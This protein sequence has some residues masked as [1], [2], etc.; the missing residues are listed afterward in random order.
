MAISCNDYSGFNLEQRN[1]VEVVVLLHRAQGC[2]KPRLV[3]SLQLRQVKL[4]LTLINRH[5]VVAVSRRDA[6]TTTS[7]D[8]N[9]ALVTLAASPYI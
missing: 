4:P 8:G 9:K 3:M 2:I 6:L 7:G 1:L 5:A